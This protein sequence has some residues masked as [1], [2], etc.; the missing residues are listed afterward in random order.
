MNKIKF[1]KYHTEFGDDYHRNY[2][3]NPLV[4]LADFSLTEIACCGNFR[5]QR[6]INTLEEED[7]DSTCGNM[8]DIEKRGHYLYLGYVLNNPEYPYERLKIS[9]EELFKVMM[10]WEK[11]MKKKPEKISLIHDNETF[12]LIEENNVIKK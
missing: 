5:L 1:L 2:I 6:L 7:D 12:E 4:I 11:L 10:K 3:D 8:I 9:K